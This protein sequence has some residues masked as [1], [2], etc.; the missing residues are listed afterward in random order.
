M[1]WVSRFVNV[2]RR[3]TV[4]RDIDE[5]LE[6]H[7]Q[8]ALE[9]GRGVHEARAAL[10]PALRW[11]EESRDIKLITWLESLLADVRFGW[12]QLTKNAVASA[13]AILPLALAIGACG[14]AFRIAD[15]MLW[16]PLPVDGADRLFLVSREGMTPEGTF[17]RFDNC[18]YPL[19]RRM[20]EAVDGQAELV[21]ISP[22]A[23]TDA[24]F[25]GDADLEKVYR[26]YVSGWMFD[27]FGVRPGLGRVLTANDDRIPGAHPVAV[28]SHDFWTRRFAQDPAVVGRVVRFDR[29]T[30]E[31]VG[32][33]DRQFTGTDPGNVTDIFVPSMMNPNVGEM[34]TQ[35]TRAFA[36]VA[37]G[38][39]VESLRDRL[40]AIFRAFQT[41][42]AA[43]FTGMMRRRI[44]E[45][46]NR[47]LVIESAATGASSLKRANE[48]PLVAV[49]LLAFVVLLVACTTVANLM[50]ARAAARE[51]EMA[52]RVSI[53]AGRWRLVQLVLLES[54]W[55]AFLASALGAALAWWSA[56][57]LVS[58]INPPD[59]PARL[60]LPADWRVA[61][62]CIATT[63]GV[64]C[65]LGLLPACRA[66][67]VKPAGAL[68][69]GA[70]VS[71]RRLMHALVGAQA[72]FCMLVLF[73]A[74]LVV[75]TFV[76]LTGQPLGFAADRLLT[77]E[78]V[79]QPAQP[80]NV[81]QQIAGDLRAVPGVDSVGVASHAMLE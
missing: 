35:W 56:P 40:Q 49:G 46:V 18:E 20:R 60:V 1:S 3:D 63:I 77:I 36:L 29:A 62:F 27:V 39:S 15:A 45:I 81:W 50:T 34:N 33:A 22:A 4:T 26:Q 59:D 79:A 58:R 44:D 14:A 43:T 21:A 30:F 13:A 32:V 76:R 54:A 51:R 28:L 17:Q 73:I 25:G 12:R 55:V 75:A 53:G 6:S 24:T 78:L 64:T 16:R 5:E 23:R 42:R 52:L 8:E 65:L 68:K 66:S 69:G 11:R 74:A 38:V 48:W 72:A 7:L 71:R 47:G 19:F 10:G 41:E 9:H 31:I 2:W 37:P 67:L 70:A 57:L 80:S 61:A